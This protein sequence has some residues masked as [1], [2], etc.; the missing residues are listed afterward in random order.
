MTVKAITIFI[1]SLFLILVNQITPAQNTFS[2]Q[3]IIEEKHDFIETD[4]LGNIYTINGD[5]IKKFNAAG[6]MLSV[7]SVRQYGKITYVDASN[8]LKILLFFEDFSAILFLDNM[9][10]PIG[11]LIA[12]ENQE[13]NMSSMACTAFDNGYWVYDSNNLQIIRFNNQNQK[14][15]ETGNLN[16][17]IPQKLKPLKMKDINNKLYFF[18]S[19]STVYVFDIFAT[20]LKNIKLSAASF[21]DVTADFIYCGNKNTLCIFHQFMLSEIFFENKNIN[22]ETISISNGR[23]LIGDKKKIYKIVR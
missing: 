19:D 21:F 14:V 20:Y 7:Y 15:V 12:L 4:P 17:I 11:N 22:I 5:E 13:V 2:V 6:K 9:L 16:R 23:E 10:N 18:N 3:P 1:T 8:P